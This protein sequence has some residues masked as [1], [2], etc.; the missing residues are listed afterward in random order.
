MPS[1]A[2]QYVDLA[3]ITVYDEEIKNYIDQLDLGVTYTLSQDPN[4]PRKIILTPSEGTGSDV[5]I[6]TDAVYLTKAQYEALDPPVSGQLY[7]ITD[8]NGAASEVID[9]TTTDIDVTW[10]SSK[11]SKLNKTTSVAVDLLNW[12]EDTTSQ[13]GVTLY[14]KPISLSHVYVDSPKV[15][16]GAGTGYTLPTTAE[17]E[18]YNLLQYVTVDSAVPCLYLYA[19]DIPTTAFY[20]NVEGVD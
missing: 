8:Y 11:I 17:Q 15:E 2:K 12:S 19:S 1:S 18:S 7:G 10:S 20:I 13:S 14:K 9:D 4:N 16:I 3:G 6:P 5:T